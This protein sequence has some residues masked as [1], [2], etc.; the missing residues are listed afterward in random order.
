M[1]FLRQLSH[2][3]EGEIVLILDNLKAHKSKPVK[4]F[5]EHNPRM[6]AVYLPPYCPELNPDEGVWNRTKTR[7]LAN[8]CARNM[9]DLTKRV[10]S[11]LWRIKRRKNVLRWCFHN[12]E[13]KWDSLLT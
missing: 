1:A 13:L 12:T 2:N 10:R 6:E 5:L 8:V 7:I 3:I 11:A 9:R 4:E